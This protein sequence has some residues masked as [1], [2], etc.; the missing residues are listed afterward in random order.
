MDLMRIVQSLEEFLYTVMTWLLFYPRTL[1]RVITRPFVIAERVETEMSAAP[2]SQ[3]S[4]MVSPPLF[5][6]LSVVIAHVLELTLHV[7]VLQSQATLASEIF[8]S[9][10]AL[11]AYRSVT[12]S[13]FPLVMASEFLR[14][15]G[16]Q[17]DRES[18]RHPFFVQCLFTAPFAVIFSAA[19]V[20]MRTETPDFQ[21]AGLVLVL[22]I[23][24]WYLRVQTLWFKAAFEIHWF[25][26]FMIAMRCFLLVL[27][28]VTAIGLVLMSGTN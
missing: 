26:A 23:I 16:S 28:L 1:W 13:T 10:Q 25:R 4:D 14:L 6:I 19:I 17:I 5:L 27:F 2:D 22:V 3:F 20:L 24:G 18:L 15:K 11:L 7:K 21:L 8:G 9:E 12:F